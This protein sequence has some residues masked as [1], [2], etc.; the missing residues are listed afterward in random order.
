MKPAPQ[1]L[2]T[3]GSKLRTLRTFFGGV[4]GVGPMIMPA[5]LLFASWS[6]QWWPLGKS[7]P[8]SIQFSGG[9]VRA[10]TKSRRNSFDPRALQEFAV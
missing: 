7:K 5:G 4:A 9:G 6:Q 10:T 3:Q 1:H 8:R 2:C